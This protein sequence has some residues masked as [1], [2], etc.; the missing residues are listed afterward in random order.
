MSDAY[1]LG[2]VGPDGRRRR[3]TRQTAEGHD[4][5]ILRAGPSDTTHCVRQD[6][7]RDIGGSW[8][9]KRMRCRDGRSRGDFETS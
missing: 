6:D 4:S 9:V 8:E 2:G 7:L 1:G 3:G 5:G